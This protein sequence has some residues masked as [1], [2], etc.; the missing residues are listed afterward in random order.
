MKRKTFTAAQALTVVAITAIVLTATSQGA[1]AGQGY[2]DLFS[3]SLNPNDLY[4]DQVNGGDGTLEDPLFTTDPNGSPIFDSASPL[5]GIAYAFGGHDWGTGVLETTNVA[6]N[7]ISLYGD[8]MMPWYLSITLDSNSDPYADSAYPSWG[9]VSNIVVSQW[10]GE[11]WTVF[12]PTWTLSPYSTPDGTTQAPG[13]VTLAAA[14]VGAAEGDVQ[15]DGVSSIYGI[16][17]TLPAAMGYKINFD[18]DLNTWDSYSLSDGGGGPGKP[19]PTSAVS[20]KEYSNNPDE[21]YTGTFNPLQNIAFEGDG[22]VGDAFDY[23]GSGLDEFHQ[24]DALAS[25]QDSYFKALVAD[26]APIVLS[27]ASPD[28]DQA[29]QIKTQSAQENIITTWATPVMVNQISPPDDVDALEIWGDDTEETANMFSVV[30][31]LMGV[32]V[33]KYDGETSTPYISSDE[34]KAA[35]GTTEY[36]DLDAMMVYD[37]ADDGI[38]ASGDSIIFSIK[39][40]L[41]GEE[42]EI[43]IFDGGEIWVWNFDDGTAEFLI[44]GGEIWNTDYDLSSA[45]SV[46]TE[47]VNA[48]EALLPTVIPGDFDGDYDVDGIDFGLWQ[49]GYPTANG[50]TL[51]DGDA[52]GDGDVDGVDFGIWQANYP[53]NMGTAATI[54]EPAT[55]ALFLIGSLAL[56]RR[57]HSSD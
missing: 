46:D 43:V 45:F 5:G 44:H 17:A 49:A 39:A 40:I 31:D 21:D 26:Q 55:L 32:A 29:G 8:I 28:A 14:D 35:I 27:F 18:T 15:S 50:A 3:V 56:L 37:I 13:S 10:D 2:W 48:L 25:S 30:D 34:L 19:P 12:D 4:W 42:D 23:S 53:T 38:F 51:S 9:T 24:V 52:D 54:P 20:G 22:Q 36:I 11:N 16:G 6:G 1:I 7:S 47:D 57:K 33:Y 41:S